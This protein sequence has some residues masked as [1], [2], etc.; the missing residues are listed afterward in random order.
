MVITA[1]AAQRLQFPHSELTTTQ[2]DFI[3][4]IGIFDREVCQPCARFFGGFDPS[5]PL[6][7]RSEQLYF[8]FAAAAVF[9]AGAFFAAAFRLA[10]QRAFIV[11]ESFRRPAAA[12][13]PRLLAAVIR[14]RSGELFGRPPSSAMIAISSRLRSAFS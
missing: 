13:P 6:F 5:L 7:R 8:F 10:A 12:I 1:K 2:S 11:C 14:T 4:F 9:C 3:L